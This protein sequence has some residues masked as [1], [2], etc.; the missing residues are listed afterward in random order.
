MTRS[1][2]GW[3]KRIAAATSTK[4]LF[5]FYFDALFTSVVPTSIIKTRWFVYDYFFG[6]RY[7]TSVL[8]YCGLPLIHLHK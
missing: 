6:S 5:F 4:V 8:F 1:W 2:I 3:I 7:V